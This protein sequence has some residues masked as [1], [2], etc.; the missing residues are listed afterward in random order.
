MTNQQ[1]S[2]M[3]LDQQDGSPPRSFGMSP[4]THVDPGDPGNW[5]M[6]N[7]DLTLLSQDGESGRHVV[8]APAWHQLPREDAGVQR[9]RGLLRSGC[10]NDARCDAECNADTFVASECRRSLFFLTKVN[11]FRQTMRVCI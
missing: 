1:D 8:K 10:R 7:G 4:F 2:D 9:F 11:R 6:I 3:H 5:I